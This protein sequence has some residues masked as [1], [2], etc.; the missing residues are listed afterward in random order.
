[1]TG[2][3][4]LQPTDAR[5]SKGEPH[6]QSRT[7]R[8]VDASRIGGLLAS[9]IEQRALV[10]ITIDGSPERYNSAL[11]ALDPVAR[12]LLLDELTPRRGHE[13]AM[14]ARRLHVL[15]RIRGVELGFASEIQGI[16]EEDGAIAYRL[17]FP[18]ALDY[19]QRRAYYRAS[20]RGHP[21]AITLFRSEEEPLRGTL[22]DI[23]V[24]GVGATFPAGLPEDIVPGTRVPSRI[25]FPDNS[26]AGDIE[27]CF[28]SR[29][30]HDR[31][32]VLGARFVGLEPA[33]Q[34]RLGQL[35][36]A[37]DRQS[38]RRNPGSR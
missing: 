13:S 17:A 8:L 4:T 6:Y 28:V 27:I 14:R 37:I 31:S 9:V 1:M 24:G 16:V 33:D 34:K 10:T 35:V 2:S 12:C 30:P 26:I 38:I 20:L 23:S 7:E 21:T 11:L 5:P 25:D 3:S 19:R 18:H 15:A 29:S 22:R 32:F 36:A